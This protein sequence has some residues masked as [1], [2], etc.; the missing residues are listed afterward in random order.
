[1]A[2]VITLCLE[3]VIFVLI[4]IAALK[5][6]LYELKETKKRWKHIISE[7]FKLLYQL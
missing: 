3:G 7:G 6:I 1:M 2:V 4:I 5:G